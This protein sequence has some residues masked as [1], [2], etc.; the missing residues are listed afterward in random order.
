[1][2]KS[3]MMACDM[4]FGMVPPTLGGFKYIF[5]Q[6]PQAGSLCRKRSSGPSSDFHKLVHVFY[7]QIAEE[8]LMAPSS[9]GVALGL[10]PSQV[11]SLLI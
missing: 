5:Y 10:T 7:M 3:L 6:Q 1:M 11:S 9:E 8:A 2:S 4:V